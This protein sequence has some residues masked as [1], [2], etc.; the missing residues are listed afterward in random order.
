MV[1]RTAVGVRRSPTPRRGLLGL[2]GLG[3]DD[4]GVLV[5]VLGDRFDRFARADLAERPAGGGADVV[6]IV[7][8]E[9]VGGVDRAGVANESERTGGV[10]AHEV[11]GV[12][13]GIELVRERL[14]RL[15][16]A[17]GISPRA[18]NTIFW[19]CG[20]E[21][22]ETNSTS[23]SVASSAAILPRIRIAN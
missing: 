18:L 5:R 14:D 2:L 13:L 16:G 7:L 23:V 11:L 15:R 22:S 1:G 20:F 17:E 3:G 4:E 6:G 9:R 21:S 19:S 10:G 8:G 12:P